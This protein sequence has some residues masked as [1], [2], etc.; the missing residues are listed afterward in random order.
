MSALLAPHR[1]VVGLQSWSL[2]RGEAGNKVSSISF[3]A[4]HVH[5]CHYQVV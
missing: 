2:T 4:L 5:K 3:L 1:K